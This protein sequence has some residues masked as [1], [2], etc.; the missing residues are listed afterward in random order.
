MSDTGTRKPHDRLSTPHWTLIGAALSA[1]VVLPLAY[2]F[3]ASAHDLGLL[4]L[5][6]GVQL[7]IPCLLMVMLARVLP[8]PEVSLLALLEVVFGV[9]WAWLGAGE[10]PSSATLTGGALVILAL[11]INEMLALRQRRR[12]FVTL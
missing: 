1:L 3:Q 8:A 7:A 5:L 4:A 2:P 11:V 10:Q 9:T 12:A 6:G